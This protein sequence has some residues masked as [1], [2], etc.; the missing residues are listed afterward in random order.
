VTW[1]T[2]SGATPHGRVGVTVDSPTPRVTGNPGK[3]IAGA[4]AAAEATIAL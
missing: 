1:Q 4:S 2:P 3:I